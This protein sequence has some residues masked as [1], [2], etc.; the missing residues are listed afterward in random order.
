MES[1]CLNHIGIVQ[2]H[3][4]EG[5]PWFPTAQT[6]PLPSQ[7]TS[8]L[9]LAVLESDTREEC[10]NIPNMSGVSR[11]PQFSMELSSNLNAPLAE[12][13]SIFVQ[14]LVLFSGINLQK[15]QFIQWLSRQQ[16]ILEKPK[17][18]ENNDGCQFTICHSTFLEDIITKLRLRND[19]P[20]LGGW[21]SEHIASQVNN[22]RLPAHRPNSWKSNWKEGVPAD[23]PQTLVWRN[24]TYICG[25]EQ[26]TERRRK[27]STWRW[28][29]LWVKLL[30]ESAGNAFHRRPTSIVEQQDPGTKNSGIATGQGWPASGIAPTC[31]GC[32]KCSSS[33]R[34]AGHVSDPV[35]RGPVA[36]PRVSKIDLDPIQINFTKLQQVC[37]MHPPGESEFC[38]I[39]SRSPWTLPLS[40]LTFCRGMIR[41]Q[42][43]SKSRDDTP[44]HFNFLD[45][46]VACRRS[47]NTT[48]RGRHRF[49]PVCR[50]QHAKQDGD[51][52]PPEPQWKFWICDLISI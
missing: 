3:L 36:W 12:S 24:I 6:M 26:K 44:V 32:C 51:L 7:T 15:R 39:D 48:A 27:K 50:G 19:S 31:L 11:C 13:Q 35:S 37:W 4:P 14:Q 38:W 40:R 8:Q 28:G 45:N 9:C 18:R 41:T 21:L 29:I 47:P 46:F 30:S 34:R 2:A 42:Q 17:L 16:T 23:T 22:V 52:R 43:S 1:K 25:F 5:S 20:H 33:G 49:A 10:L